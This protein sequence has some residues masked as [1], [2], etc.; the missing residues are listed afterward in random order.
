M[1]GC[2]YS[3]RIRVLDWEGVMERLKVHAVK[4]HPTRNSLHKAVHMMI[5][6]SMTGSWRDGRNICNQGAG[7]GAQLH[8]GIEMHMW[9]SS[10]LH[11]GDSVPYSTSGPVGNEP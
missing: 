8:P 2:Q 11:L 1:P 9:H 10:G 6:H 4:A 7:N 5:L 3:M